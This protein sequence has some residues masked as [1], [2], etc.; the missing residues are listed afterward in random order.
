MNRER[1]AYRNI[2]AVYRYRLISLR[3]NLM[4]RF[5][6]LRVTIL[7][8]S[9]ILGMATFGRMPV[10]LAHAGEHATVEPG[11]TLSVVARS[12]GVE[13][14]VLR[15]LNNLDDADYIRAGQ[16]LALPDI[17]LT[18][19]MPQLGDSTSEEAEPSRFAPIIT[20]LV[21]YLVQPG[22]SLSSIAQA[23]RISLVL[24]VEI[25]NISPMQR[26]VPGQILRA[27][28]IS[29]T[30]AT[31]SAKDMTHVVQPGEHLGVIA[32]RYNTTARALAVTNNLADPSLI[33]P[34]QQLEIVGPGSV[35]AEPAPA[36]STGY[37][38]HTDFPTT[39]EKWIDVD[40]SEQR[41]VA[42]EGV[43]P[44][45]SFVV[46]TGLPGTPTVTG[47]FR[48]WAK[49]QIQD[50]YGG[51]R[52]S[53]TYYYLPNVQWVQYFYEDYAFHGTYWH[54]N[55][56][57]PMSR[58]CVNMTNEDARWLFEWANPGVNTV[59]WFFSATPEEGTLVVVHE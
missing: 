57:Q 10:A 58:G 1:F 19:D 13:T 11:D 42:Y 4:R 32:A 47:T 23:H 36:W 53:G 16:Q 14:S 24:L 39:T 30:A 38:E 31:A 17:S 51:S 27:P 8:M 9:I 26:L 50:M 2:V 3:G 55:F 18:T 25:N 20:N 59:G 54:S 41:M 7:S 40:L 28:A 33:V 21:D 46:S 12:Y 45:R 22:D 52:A 34:G 29:A 37:H 5:T 35:A 44:V 56:G 48:I 15:Q 49:T 43:T 6:L